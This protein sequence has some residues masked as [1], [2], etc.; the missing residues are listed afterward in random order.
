[1]FNCF[2][3]GIKE[4]QSLVMF[5]YLRYPGPVTQSQLCSKGKHNNLQKKNQTIV[6][7]FFKYPRE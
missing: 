4:G 5:Y 6:F 7:L 3:Q 1:M 2:A